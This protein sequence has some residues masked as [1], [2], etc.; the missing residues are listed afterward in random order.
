M[1]SCTGGVTLG[2]DLVQW[3]TL[4]RPGNPLQRAGFGG[5]VL[6]YTVSLEDPLPILTIIN[7]RVLSGAA[8]HPGEHS[9]PTGFLGAACQ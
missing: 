3:S 7:V 2:E 5:L 6:R 1:V 4:Q 9:V 8:L